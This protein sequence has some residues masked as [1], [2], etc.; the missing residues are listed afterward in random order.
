MSSAQHSSHARRESWD[1]ILLPQ[2]LPNPG[3]SQKVRNLLLRISDLDL[4]LQETALN[5]T[6]SHG[7]KKCFFSVKCIFLFWEMSVKVL[8]INVFPI[9][10]Q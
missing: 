6:E 9:P 1:N 4:M 2:R 10:L 8:V 3:F 7:E 5:I